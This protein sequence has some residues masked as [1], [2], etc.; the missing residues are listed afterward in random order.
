M[1]FGISVQITIIEPGGFRT[2]FVKGGMDSTPLPVYTKPTLKGVFIRNIFQN[3][4]VMPGDTGKAVEVIY[5]LAALPDPPLHLPLGN[6]SIAGVR[7]KTAKLL[8]ETDKFESW[9]QGLDATD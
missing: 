4:P 7:R 8:E 2:D 3:D 9:S 1:P 5:R 6:D